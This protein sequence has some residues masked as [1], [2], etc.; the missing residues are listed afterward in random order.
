MDLI[1]KLLAWNWSR[2]EGE[3]LI[4]CLVALHACIRFGV[5]EL[6]PCESDALFTF[7]GG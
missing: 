3:F 7:G 2:T 1:K 4:D 6:P 5:V